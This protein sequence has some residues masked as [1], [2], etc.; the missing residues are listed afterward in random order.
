MA[1]ERREYIKIN[2]PMIGFLAL[3]TSVAIA[4][5]WEIGEFLWDIYI[6]IPNGFQRFAQE[7]LVDTMSDLI[8]NNLSSTFAAVIS[9]YV[10]KKKISK[11]EIKKLSKFKVKT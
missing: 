5:Y 10:A 6:T 2:L 11:K 7:G 9:V 3:V 8:W 1:Y 4:A